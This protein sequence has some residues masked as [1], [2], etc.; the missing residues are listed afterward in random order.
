M[1]IVIDHDLCTGHGRCYVLGP[2]LF[3]DDD[4]GYGQVIGDGTFGEESRRAADRAVLACPEQAI[5]IEGG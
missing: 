1:R 5:S 3:R 4:N 2:A